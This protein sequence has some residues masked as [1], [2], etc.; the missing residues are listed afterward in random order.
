MSNHITLKELFNNASIE[1]GIMDI[2]TEVYDKLY[3]LWLDK[4]CNVRIKD[5][6]PFFYLIWHI[7]HFVTTLIS[8]AEF[9]L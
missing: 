1:I 4:L 2:T 8:V 5:N 3:C 6:M 7:L 9:K